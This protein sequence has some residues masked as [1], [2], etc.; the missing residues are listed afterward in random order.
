MVAFVRSEK[1]CPV[2]N[3]DQPSK[4]KHILGWFIIILGSISG[5][6]LDKI[7]KTSSQVFKF[8]IGKNKGI[9]SPSSNNFF[10]IFHKV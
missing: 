1:Y 4:H 5:Q 8:P 10:A 3:S 2:A 6:I 7:D 9:I